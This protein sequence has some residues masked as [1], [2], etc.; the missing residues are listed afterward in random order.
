MGRRVLWLFVVGVGLLVGS[1]SWAQEPAPT[2]EVASVRPNVSGS[3]V[4]FVR[5]LEGGRFEA[6]NVPL[7]DLIALAYGLQPYERVESGAPRIDDRFDIVA[8]ADSASDLRFGRGERITPLNRMLQTLLAQRF[9]LVVHREPRPLTGFN[10]VLARDDGRLGPQL[11]RSATDCAALRAQGAA[12]PMH[13]EGF[14]VCVIYGR[15]SRVRA[16][17]HTLSEFARSLSTPLKAPI[18]DM[19][20]LEGPFEIDISYLDPRV[21]AET[22]T[23]AGAALPSLETALKEQLGLKLERAAGTMD[24]VVVDRLDPLLEN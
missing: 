13:P 1:L 7:R 5:P 12:L 20:G 15:N 17:G 23:A 22:A 4:S 10:L 2:F 14:G 18:Q 16:G 8:R 6:I 3:R 9:N 24:A 19:T 21:S 11:R